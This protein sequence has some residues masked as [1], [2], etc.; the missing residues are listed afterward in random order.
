MSALPMWARSSSGGEKGGTVWTS[1]HP[2]ADAAVAASASSWLSSAVR[3]D[4]APPGETVPPGEADTTGMASPPQAARI[5]PTANTGAIHRRK[6]RGLSG[7]RAL[8]DR[9][10]RFRSG[11]LVRQALRRGEPVVRHEVE[12]HRQADLVA[13]L[14]VMPCHQHHVLARRKLSRLTLVRIGV[15]GH[16]H[17]GLLGGL[18]EEFLEPGQFVGLL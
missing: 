9:G 8:A 18:P 13:R 15:R 4:T 7:M 17:L 12:G 1:P 11:A 6:G 16:D 3:S 5:I 14:Q 2:A 10:V